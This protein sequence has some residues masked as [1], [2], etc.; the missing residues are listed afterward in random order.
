MSQRTGKRQLGKEESGRIRGQM[1][2]GTKAERPE[3]LREVYRG[4]ILVWSTGPR[5]EWAE[6]GQKDRG[7]WF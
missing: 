3:E 1:T 5:P 6:K 4:G 7:R 2:L